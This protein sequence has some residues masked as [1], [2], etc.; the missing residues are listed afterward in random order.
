[1]TGG[2]ERSRS[3]CNLKYD[4]YIQTVG[5]A[6]FSLN[7]LNINFTDNI[8]GSFNRRGNKKTRQSKR[9]F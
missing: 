2:N 4:E 1:M 9:V 8:I 6:P 5:F 3:T 7:R